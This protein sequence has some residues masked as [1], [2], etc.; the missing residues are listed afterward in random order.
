MLE[1]GFFAWLE[2]LLVKIV[3][4]I[5]QTKAWFD[6]TEFDAAIGEITGE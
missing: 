3:E 1:N 6:N 2:A 5:K 4:M